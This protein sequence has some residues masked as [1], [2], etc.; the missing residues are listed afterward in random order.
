M[1]A[2]P[3]LGVK[4]ILHNT[5]D[6]LIFLCNFFIRGL[7]VL[8]HGQIHIVIHGLNSKII[9]ELLDESAILPHLHSLC[10]STIDKADML[11]PLYH[12]VKIVGGNTVLR[13]IGRQPKTL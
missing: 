8:W 3:W 4:I 13:L 2:A 7:K 11:C 6:V 10:I 5:P 1:F 9:S 12:Y